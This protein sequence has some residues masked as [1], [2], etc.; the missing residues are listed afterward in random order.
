VD[1]NFSAEEWNNLTRAEQISRCQTL[2]AESQRLARASE[3]DLK[4]MYLDLAIHWLRLA[5]AI[6]DTPA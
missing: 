1:L 6:E 2:A 5:E 4:V 3:P